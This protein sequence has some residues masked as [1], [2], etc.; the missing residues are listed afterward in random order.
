ME[1][2][3]PGAVVVA[4]D[5]TRRYGAGDTAV[6]ALR[7]VSLEVRAGQA[8][9][10]DGAVRL[11]QVD[12]DAHPRRARQ[13]DHRHGRR[14]GHR[15]HDAQGLRPDQ[16]AP[17]PHRLRLPVLQPAADADGGGEHH[18]AAVDRRRE[19]RSDVLRRSDRE[20]RARRPAP[21]PALR[22]LRWPA[23]A[24]R[25]RSRARLEADGA[26]RRRADRQPRLV[27]R[28]RDPRVDARLGRLVR[29][30]DGDGHARAAGGCDR[31]PDP[32]PRRRPD[33]PR[34]PGRDPGG[35]ARRR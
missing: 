8:D 13:A 1:N 32:L 18:A 35:G 23:A 26:V 29:P 12:A 6:D 27:D 14:L 2:G 7:G 5:V 33:R 17:P 30:D 28:E 10:R 20:G 9:R 15:D 4:S 31:R 11:R 3:K 22:A 19:A 25:D 21:S 16:A 34:P 24:R